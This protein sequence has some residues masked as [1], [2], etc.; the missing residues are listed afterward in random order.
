M[1]QVCRKHPTSF[2]VRQN[3]KCSLYGSCR[4]V[5]PRTRHRK[6][7]KSET[8]YTLRQRSSGGSDSHRVR[9]LSDIARLPCLEA[10]GRDTHQVLSCATI[11]REPSRCQENPPDGYQ[12]MPAVLIRA[13]LFPKFID[14]QPNTIQT[15]P[16]NKLH[17]CTMP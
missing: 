13:D 9:P 3:R 11:P 4:T 5:R 12:E 17:V 14:D 7:V 10:A 6:D 1:S 8:S 2:V 15:T 16:Y